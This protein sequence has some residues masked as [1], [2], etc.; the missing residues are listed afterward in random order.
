MSRIPQAA[1]AAIEIFGKKVGNE[2]VTFAQASNAGA[3]PCLIVAECGINHGGDTARA[4]DMVRAAADA[5]V[6]VVKFQ[7]RDLQATYT[8]EAFADPNR[9][10]HGLAHYLPVLKQTQLPDKDYPRLKA[11]AEALGL[12]FLVTPFDE[13]SVDFLEALCVDAYKVASCDFNN[14]FLH[15]KI[16]ATGKPVIVSTGMQHEIALFEVIPTLKEMFPGRLALMH[17][18]SSYP[19]AFRDC[20]LHSILRMKIN[21]GVPVGWSGHERGVAVSTSAAALG[22]DIIERHFTLDRTLPGPDQAASL[23]PDGLKKLV[24]RIRATEDAYGDPYSTK[25]PTRGEAQTQEILGKSLCARRDIKAGEPVTMD[26]LEARSPGRGL[27]P[28]LATYL[29]RTHA[30]MARDVAAGVHLSAQDIDK[31]VTVGAGPC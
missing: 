30:V 20:Q 25:V 12:G 28:F 7:R 6:D 5:G 14:P 4:M 11:L 3:H 27:S 24:E 26:M 19:T 8:P 1:P 21:H 23:E 17:T 2:A 22:A 29:V 13:P 31:K 18:V 16:A 9:A 10:A 15:A